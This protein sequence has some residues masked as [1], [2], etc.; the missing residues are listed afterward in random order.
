MVSLVLGLGARP[1]PNPNPAARVLTG[2]LPCVKG[3][4]VYPTCPGQDVALVRRPHPA[5]NMTE[6]ITQDAT[7]T[8]PLNPCAELF[9]RLLKSPPEIP[10]AVENTVTSRRPRPSYT[11]FPQA[12]GSAI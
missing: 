3:A 12:T 6:S 1:S 2:D 8:I 11:Q 9:E 4:V 10:K 5:I 7:I